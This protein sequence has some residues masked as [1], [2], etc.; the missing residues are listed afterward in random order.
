MKDSKVGRLARE[1]ASTEYILS[2]LS[3]VL[4]IYSHV[5]VTVVLPSRKEKTHLN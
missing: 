3:S 2:I 5:I 4:Q 1:M